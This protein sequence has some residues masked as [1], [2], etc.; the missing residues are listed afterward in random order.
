M[1]QNTSKKKEKSTF[2]FVHLLIQEKKTDDLWKGCIKNTYNSIA[3]GVLKYSK[4]D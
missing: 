3:A 1:K 2:G 4:H